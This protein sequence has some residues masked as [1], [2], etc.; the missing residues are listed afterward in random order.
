MITVQNVS[1]AFGQNLVIDQV[2]LQIDAGEFVAFVGPS[3]CG[4]TTLMRIIAD[5]VPLSSGKV[6][7]GGKTPREARESRV[8]GVVFQRSAALEWHT[9]L[10]D[11]QFTL[12]IAHPKAGLSPEGLLEQFGLAGSFHKYPHQLSGGMLQRENIA[13]ALVHNP[14]I[15]LMDE[16]FAALDEMRREEISE[17]LMGLIEHGLAGAPKTVLLIT[18]SVEEAVYMADRVVVFSCPPA[19]IIADIKVPLPRPRPNQTTARAMDE[20]VQTAQ[21]VR[22]VLY[23]PAGGVSCER[24]E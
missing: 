21:T 3:G 8:F 24:H 20:F 9:A 11:V 19:H 10:R 15:L 7:V 1:K 16:P 13:A 14:P 6:T 23:S 18:H 12:D 2:S 17:W 5:L 22:K 4:K